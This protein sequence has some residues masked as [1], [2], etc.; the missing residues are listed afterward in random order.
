MYN[1]YRFRSRREA[2]GSNLQF[3][4]HY[5]TKKDEPILVKV[6]ISAISAANAL[7]NLEAEIPDWDFD[8]VRRETRAKWERELRQ[9]SNRR[10]ARDKETFYT[11]LY[12]CFI[13]PNLYEDVTGEYCGLDHN[14]HR[15]SGFTNYAVYSLWDTYRAEHPLLALIQTPRDADMINSML[16]YYDQSVEHLLPIWALP[17]NETWCMIGYHAVPVI[18]DG[19]PEGR[20][21]FRSRSGRTRR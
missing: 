8:G 6:G 9:D 2:A 5:K 10:L 17:S 1:T 21:G 19:Y 13:T 7:K 14:I 16:A 15:A 4:A 11:G 18:A 12:H 3:L 20:A